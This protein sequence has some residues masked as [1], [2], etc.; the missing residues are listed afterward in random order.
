MSILNKKFEDITSQDIDALIELSI[1]E[2]QK[3]EFK[4]SVWGRGDE[5]I[6][7]MLRDITSMANAY[8]GYILI[9]LKEN[10]ETGI[11]QEVESI[12]NADDEKDRIFSS[13]L[14]N[15]EPRIIGLDIKTIEID[16]ENKILLMKIPNSLNL[17]I[18]TFR[19]LYQFWKRHDRQKTRMTVD[20][21]KDSFFVNHSYDESKKDFIDKRDKDI[22]EII[23]NKPFFILGAIPQKINNEAVN[24]FD[25]EIKNILQDSIEGERHAGW[26]FSQISLLG[27]TTPTF[28]G[29]RVG[30]NHIYQELHRNGYFEAGISLQEH[31]FFFVSPEEYLERQSQLPPETLDYPLLYNMPVVEYTLS[32]LNKLKLISNYLNEETQYS[33]FIKFLN[34]KKMI[35]KPYRQGIDLTEHYYNVWERNDLIIEPMTFEFVDPVLMTKEVCDRVWQAF[36][37][38]KQPYYNSETN[39]FEFGR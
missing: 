19:G 30:A 2:S 15:I 29:L 34:T 7:E 37:Y 10:S 26:N 18:I 21:I 31:S 6:R 27:M 36:G 5:D 28:Y 24:I 3:L 35:M 8:G 23:N 32:F 13:C 1:S 4:Q 22:K 17:H 39:S 14:A 38:E 11:A 20:E 25:E 33:I 16:E 9:G 12:I